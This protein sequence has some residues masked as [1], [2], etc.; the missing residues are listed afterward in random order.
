MFQ[1]CCKV[2]LRTQI[3][4]SCIQHVH[5]G[6]F[7]LLSGRHRCWPQ[8]QRGLVRPGTSSGVHAAAPPS[9][10]TSYWKH[11]RLKAPVMQAGQLSM[12]RKRACHR[13]RDAL[14]WPDKPNEHSSLCCM[15]HRFSPGDVHLK[16][17][18]DEDLLSPGCVRTAFETPSA[19]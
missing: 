2:T 9:Q 8:G 5:K 14:L 1:T 16:S 19:T 10:K 3:C 13:A 12:T 18:T 4:L 17:P 6:V 7:R 11:V 15:P